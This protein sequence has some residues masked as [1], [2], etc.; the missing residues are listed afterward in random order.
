M[1]SWELFLEKR[2]SHVCVLIMYLRNCWIEFTT[3]FRLRGTEPVCFAY[4]VLLE[5]LHA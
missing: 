3:L 2:F 1:E 5:D 4:F